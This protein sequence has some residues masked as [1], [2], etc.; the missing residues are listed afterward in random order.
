MDWGQLALF[1]VVIV[2]LYLVGRF[3]RARGYVGSG[4]NGGDGNGDG[5]GGGDGGD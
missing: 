2:V 5:D 4:R 1:I 3:L